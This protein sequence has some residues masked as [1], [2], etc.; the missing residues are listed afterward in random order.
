[1]M[2][3]TFIFYLLTYS[4]YMYAFRP[5][6]SALPHEEADMDYGELK[7]AVFYADS[8]YFA[9]VHGDYDRSMQYADST[10]KYMIKSEICNFLI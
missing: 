8:V 7:W 5:N 4:Q 6:I 9:N 3:L 2:V 1:M 10:F